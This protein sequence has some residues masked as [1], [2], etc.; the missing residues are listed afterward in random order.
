MRPTTAND[1]NVFN[2]QVLLLPFGNMMR[3]RGCPSVFD[4]YRREGAVGGTP[5]DEVALPIANAA[6]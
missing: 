6:R 3:L 4:T 2:F 5:Q 1:D